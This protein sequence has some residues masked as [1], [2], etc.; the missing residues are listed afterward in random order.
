MPWCDDCQK[1]WNPNSM[2]D[3]GECPTCQRE[4]AELAA[5]TQA[6]ADEAAEA[7][8]PS[9][10]VNV[11]AAIDTVRPLPPIVPAGGNEGGAARPPAFDA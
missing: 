10:R 3:N 7:P 2:P 1:F 4:V 5:V 11:L 6:L 8:P 9:L